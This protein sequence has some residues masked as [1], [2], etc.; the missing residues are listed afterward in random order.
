MSQIRSIFRNSQK[1]NVRNERIKMRKHLNADTL[2]SSVRTGFDKITDHRPGDVNISLTDSLMSGFAVFSLKDP[3]LLAFDKRR[4]WYSHNLCTIYGIESIPCDSTMREILDGVAPNDFRPLFKGIFSKLQRGKAL[5]KFVYMDDCYL[6]SLDGT[7]YFSSPVLHSPSC[8]EK[9]NKKT[10]EVISYYIQMLGASI[11]HPDRKEVIPLCPEPIKKQDG[12]TKNDCERNAA[13]RFLADLRRE[14]PHLPLIVIEDALSSNAPHIKDLEKNNLH[15]ILGAKEGDH[16]FLFDCV[17]E[18]ATKGKTTDLI[19]PDENNPAIDHCFSFINN[20]PLNKS[21]QD[22]LV[23]F[24][25]YWQINIQTGKAMHFCWVTDFTV[26]EDNMFKIMRGGRARWKI[27]NETFNTLKN[28]GY[29]F[30]HN[31]GLGKKNLSM[32]FVM[33]MMLAFLVDQAQQICC[34]LF[35]AVWKMLS[36]KRQL[37]EDIR[38]VFRYYHVDSMETLYRAILNGGSGQNLPI[39]TIE[40]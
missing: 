39:L 3:S 31:Y 17:N 30:G 12:E 7:G 19:I 21:N 36:S 37:W 27:E 5:E 32:I 10:G 28:Q 25:E 6:L 38:S 15:Y 29:N 34:S 13:K 11:V 33:L 40:Q 24:I 8:M 2:I 22:V 4:Q 1:T 35:G 16:G 9:I 20:V 26:T 23:N 18:A 14:H